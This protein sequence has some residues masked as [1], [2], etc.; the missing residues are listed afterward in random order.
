MNY[1]KK[2]IC[3]ANSRKISGRCIAGKEITDDGYGEWIRP[4]SSRPTGEISEY[5]RRFEDGGHPQILDV[6]TIPLI[7]HQPHHYQQENHLIDDGFYWEKE[8]AVR[9]DELCS[10]VDNIPNEMWVNGYSSY[11]GINDRIPEDVANSLE[12]SL[13]LVQPDTL[14]I[15]VS[16]EG[17]EFGGGK[18]KVRAIFSVNDHQYKLAVTDPKIESKYLKK[19]DG[20][21]DIDASK[22]YI[23]VSIGEPYN[24]YCYKLVASIIYE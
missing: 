14:A 15:S 20:R 1:T 8:G 9:V 24:G 2:I 5:E 6:I 21:Y 13:L 7:K 22:V 11:N 18:R 12:S 16:V 3:L 19:E 23:C 4:V 17:A 10:M